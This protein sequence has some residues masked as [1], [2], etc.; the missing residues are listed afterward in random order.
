MVRHGNAETVNC[1]GGADC[2][3]G[4]LGLL[5][6]VTDGAAVLA[7]FFRALGDPARLRLLEFLVAGERSVGECVR[8]IGLVQGRVSTHLACLADCGYVEV[9][10]QGRFSYYRVADPRV[11]DLV[12]LARALAADNAAVL[13]ACRRID[14]GAGAPDADRT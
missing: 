11:V 12:H 1:A 10:R 13:A 3:A 8:H 14:A 7:K 6:E 5:P 4:P 2:C 9:R